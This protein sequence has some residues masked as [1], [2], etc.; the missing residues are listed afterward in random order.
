MKLDSFIQEVANVA[1]KYN[2]FISNEPITFHAN[3][4]NTRF[5]ITF[6]ILNKLR[7]DKDMIIREACETC[8]TI[9]NEQ[10]RSKSYKHRCKACVARLTKERRHKEYKSKNKESNV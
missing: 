3:E 6:F 7:A 9:L 10:N 4:I 2:V 8:G 5:S 1:K